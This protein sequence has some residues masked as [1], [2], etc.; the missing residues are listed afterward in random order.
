MQRIN[1][2]V[3]MHCDISNLHPI[4]M[5]DRVLLTY[6]YCHLTTE[7]LRDRLNANGIKFLNAYCST[8]CRNVN[9]AAVLVTLDEYNKVD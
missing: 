5:E 6:T 7:Q 8:D 1:K 3:G 2:A 9:G 4:M